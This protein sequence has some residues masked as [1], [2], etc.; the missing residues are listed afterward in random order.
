MF[1]FLKQTVIGH[2]FLLGALHKENSSYQIKTV[3]IIL[4]DRMLNTAWWFMQEGML[5]IMSG[6]FANEV[7]F[8]GKE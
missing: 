5:I 8:H 2:G 1:S 6:V 7:T 4:R 3:C